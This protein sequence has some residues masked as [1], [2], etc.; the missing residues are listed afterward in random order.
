MK[1]HTKAYTFRYDDKKKKESVEA[2]RSIL[3]YTFFFL[4]VRA[5]LCHTTSAVI[6]ALN[7]YFGL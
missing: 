5:W 4:N 3:R 1:G 6:L 7:T 2:L